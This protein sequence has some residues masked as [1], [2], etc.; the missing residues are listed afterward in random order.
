M[1][2]LAYMFW[3]WQQPAVTP[4]LYETQLRAFHRALSLDPPAGF[5]Q[6]SSSALHGAP[7]ANDGAAA[8][9]DRY[10]IAT[11]AALDALDDWVKSGR[12]HTA[13]DGAARN[14]AG[15]VAGLYAARLGTPPSRPRFATWFTK[16]AGMRYD[17]LF[18]YCE[19]AIAASQSV[20][21]MRRMVLGPTME[22]CLE[23]MEPADMPGEFSP[24]RLELTPVI[25]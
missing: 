5:L 24:L 21:W 8:Y 20:L 11:S 16:P 19:G 17:E 6:S 15:G 10:L 7:W 18:A 22:F 9:H 1:S 2:A 13:H 14:A 4:D 12:A 25:G 3:H 23:G